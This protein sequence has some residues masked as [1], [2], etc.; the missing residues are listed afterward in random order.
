MEPG[1]RMSR[2][3][4][5]GLLSPLQPGTI[6]HRDS[7]E[8]ALFLVSDLRGLNVH[9]IVEP[10]ASPGTSNLV[11]R[12]TRGKSAEGTFELDNF[13]SRFTGEHRFGASANVNS[14]F[15]RGDLLSYRG[16]LGVPGGGKD[17]DFG[18]VSYMTPVGTTGTKVGAA[19]SA[20][21]YHLGT[22]TF[23]GLDQGGRA[24]ATS[25]FA[26]HPFVRTR[27][28]NVFGHAS[29]DVRDFHDEF[30]GAGFTIEKR[31]KLATLGVVGDSRDQR[32]G[33]GINNFSLAYTTGKLD[34][35]TPALRVADETVGHG[36][37]GGYGRLNGSFLRLNA[38][39][40]STLLL[41]SYAFQLASG[42]LD[43]SEKISLGGPNAVRAYSI[44]EAS[45]DDAQFLTAELR[46]GLDL[47]NVPGNVV[48]S[49]FFDAARGKINHDPLP[50]DPSNTRHLR[51]VGF[52]ATWAR[53]DDFQLRAVIAWRVTG[54][55][56]S[57]PD[58]RKPRF[59]FQAI[60]FL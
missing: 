60:K 55:A 50:R 18:R 33:G 21:A 24:R 58:D 28:L 57:D 23:E 39:S 8:R 35:K 56:V 6:I 30:R 25:L 42:N 15:G 19:F 52:G 43:V 53:Q 36:T 17:L 5:E 37:Q 44:G 13:G 47:K 16:L 4:V 41:V 27:N 59:Y 12:I 10:G 7:L 51:G 34:I 46:H 29:V 14:P 3:I 11:V 1:L 54:A 22:A 2:D 32:F 49:A 40:G 38:L 9:S 20:L 26:L 31:T 45:S 48:L